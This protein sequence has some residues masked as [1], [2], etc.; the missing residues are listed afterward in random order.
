VTKIKVFNKGTL[1]GSKGLIPLGGQ[2]KPTSPKGFKLKCR[3]VQKN[4]KKNITSLKINKSIPALN[5][6]CDEKECLPT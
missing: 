4:L 2:L 3:K 5:L 1:N 6:T